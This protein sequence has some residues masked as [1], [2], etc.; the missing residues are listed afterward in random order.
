MSLVNVSEVIEDPDFNQSFTVYRKTGQW[1]NGRFVITETSFDSNGVII[2]QSN[3]ELDITAQGSLISSKISIWAHDLLYV[4]S[5]EGTPQSG[6]YLSDEVEFYGQRYLIQA[7][8]NLNDYGYYKY[9]L[10]LKVAS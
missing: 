9:E 6:D 7:A 1:V 8:R 2:S 10:V 3:E 4:T 5:Q